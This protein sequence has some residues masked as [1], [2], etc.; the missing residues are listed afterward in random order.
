M[1]L[2][3][4]TILE[5]FENKDEV[6][7][8]DTEVEMD[9]VV[10]MNEFLSFLDIEDKNIYLYD[11]TL[12]ILKHENFNYGIRLDSGGRGDFFSHRIEAS[13][14]KGGLK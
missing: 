11:G 9:N 6:Y 5:L 13:V 8:F 10:S 14:Y 1:Q 7:D 2:E 12:V 4:L 3:E